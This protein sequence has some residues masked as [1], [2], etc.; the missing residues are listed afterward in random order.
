MDSQL[1]LPRPKG[2]ACTALKWPITPEIMEHGYA[3]LYD[4]LRSFRSMSRSAA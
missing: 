3:F 4:A 2:V 1:Y